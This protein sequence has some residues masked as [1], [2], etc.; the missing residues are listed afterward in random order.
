MLD[1]RIKVEKDSCTYTDKEGMY[2]VKFY[3]E[4]GETAWIG[5]TALRQALAAMDAIE[6][7]ED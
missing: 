4:H 5:E 2:F 7:Y 6:H 1:M 3:G